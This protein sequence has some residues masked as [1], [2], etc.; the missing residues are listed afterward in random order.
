M[1][2]K[3]LFSLYA[4]L[5]AAIASLGL[6]FLFRDQIALL[7]PKGLIAEKQSHLMLISTLLMLIV[8]IPVFLLTLY[9]SIKYRAGN[10]KA[11]YTPE[12]DHSYLAES[13]WWGFPCVIIAILSFIAWKSSHELDPYKPLESDKKPL[14]IQVVA[15]QW[16]W[17]FLYPEQKIASLNFIQ[18]PKDTPINF[19]ITSDAPMNSFWI[20]ELGGQIYAMPGMKTKLHLI[21]D[22][23]G[24]FRGS[25]ANLSGEG[26]SSMVFIAKAS[27]E[28]DF[29]SWLKNIDSSQTLDVSEYNELA[30]PSV[31]TPKSFY[32]LNNDNLFNWIVMKPMREDPLHE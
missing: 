26:F 2:K 27:T 30:K 1:N 29:E 13:V 23:V 6:V 16:K 12:W 31:I 8:V 24:E 5:L 22:T 3:Y 9:I 28:E 18:F 21:A 32:K 7:N 14:T 10:K 4:L 17:L 15:L 20:P 19:E 11:S 25:S